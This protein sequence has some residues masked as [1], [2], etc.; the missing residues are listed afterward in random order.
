MFKRLIN[1]SRQPALAKLIG[2]LDYYRFPELR[3]KSDGPLPRLRGAL[4]Y[5]FLPDTRASWGGPLNGQQ[6]R[7]RMVTTLLRQVGIEAIVE[8][9]TYRGTSTE[10]FADLCA[11]P[12]VTIEAD[13]RFYGYSRARLWKRRNVTGLLADS[14]VGLRTLI[15]DDR[16]KGRRVLF[17]LDAHWGQDLPLAEEL[18]LIF[19][20]WSQAVVLV[21]DFQVPDDAGYAFDDY[22]EGKAL[23]PAYAAGALAKCALTPFFP[24]A[25][26]SEETGAK[27]GCIVLAAHADVIQALRGVDGLRVASGA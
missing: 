12:V 17:Y 13:R 6:E 1:R 26:S 18:D 5:Y 21:D 20:H 27:R 19:E 2:A 24:T 9:G 14:R 23:T 11:G 8:T 22:G 10:F 15:D 25:H 16:L 4:D 3:A 7:R